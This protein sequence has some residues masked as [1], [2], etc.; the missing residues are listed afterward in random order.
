MDKALAIDKKSTYSISNAWCE[1]LVVLLIL[2]GGVS[3]AGYASRRVDAGIGASFA[4]RFQVNINTATQ[5]ELEVLP[6][7]GETLAKRIVEY[8]QRS[9]PYQGLDDLSQVQGVGP[10]MLAQMEALVTF[11]HMKP[12]P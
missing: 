12:L 3:V 9:G 6:D 10:A 8:R 1:L 2:M 7:V 11:G 4:P 5:A